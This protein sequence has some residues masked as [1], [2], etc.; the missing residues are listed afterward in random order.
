MNLSKKIISALL[1]VGVSLSVAACSSSSTDKQLKAD[2][3]KQEAPVT[4][5]ISAAASLK[6]SLDKIKESYKNV[7]SNVTLVFNYGASGTLQQQIEQGADVDIFMSAATKQMDALSSKNLLL[8]DTKS[9]LLE[10]DVVLVIPK[11]SSNS[12]SDFKSLTDNSIK[13]VAIGEPSSVPAGQYGEEVLT[14]LGILDKVKAKAV[15][16]KDVTTVLNWVET[17]NADA[18]IVYKTDALSSSKVKIAATAP[19]DSHKAVVYPVAVIK[20]SKKADAAK[21]FLKYLSSSDSKTIFENA[22]FKMSSN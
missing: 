21:E 10:N 19:S 20:A 5:N 22:G 8:E 9:N 16:A 12:I 6:V 2:E 17:G 1:A 18:G 4:L 15:Y 7:K 14:K 3:K 13:K 11:D